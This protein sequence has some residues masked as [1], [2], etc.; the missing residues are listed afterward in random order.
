TSVLVR[1][2][3]LRVGGEAEPAFLAFL[4]ALGPPLFFYAFHVYTETPSALAVAGSLVLL[5]GAPGPGGAPAAALLAAALPWLP[6][7]MIPA[8]AAL[9][10]VAAARLRGRPRLVFL[11]AAA[12]M[13]VGFLAY[14]QSV[15]GHPTPLA[16]YAGLPAEARMSPLPA[17]FGLALDR[18]FGL[19]PHAP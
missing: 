1:A 2:L 12:A 15:L 19:L 17:L 16:L 4:A 11:A 18:S 6:V 9:G 13:A 8:A 10:I 7:K 3:A 14:Y 5:L